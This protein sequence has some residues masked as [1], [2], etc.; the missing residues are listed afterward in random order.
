MGKNN[1]DMNTILGSNSSYEG[2]L[3][4]DG[5]MRIE[6]NFK[7]EIN[8]VSVV[9]GKNAKVNA[10]IKASSVIVG[11]EIEGNINTKKDLKLQ[12]SAKVVGDVDTKSLIIEE[13]AILQGK[14][15]MRK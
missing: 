9:I 13:G 4:V 6:G 11:G 10:D 14:C 12:K 5:S 3:K 8:A 1:Y 2:Q 15:K 7:G